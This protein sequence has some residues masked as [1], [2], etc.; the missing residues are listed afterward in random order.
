MASREDLEKLGPRKRKAPVDDNGEPV[1]TG[2]TGRKKP[3]PAA[4]SS[5]KKNGPQAPHATTRTT[6]T[7]KKKKTTTGPS[8]S[9]SSRQKSPAAQPARQNVQ[10]PSVDSE[11]DDDENNGNTSPDVISVNDDDSESDETVLSDVE[12][13]EEELSM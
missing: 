1:T 13:G 3:K 7:Q 2:S 10:L 4:Q 8:T 9:Q 12:T 5:T 6:S 11:I